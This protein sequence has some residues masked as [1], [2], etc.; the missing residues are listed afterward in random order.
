MKLV[1]R[2]SFPIEDIDVGD[3][4]RDL[5]EAWVAALAG[6]IKAE[7]QLQD[8]EL[9]RSGNRHR[10]SFGAHRLAAC[11]LLGLEHVPSKIMETETDHPELEIRL[12]EVMENIGRRELSA[13]DRAGHLAELKRIYEALNP[14]SKRGVAGAKKKHNPATAIFAVADE[15][16]G[17]IG[18]SE[19]SV[20]AAIALWDGL[21]PETRKALAGTWLADHQAQLSQLSRIEPKAQSKI[22]SLLLPP[23]EGVEPK[24]ATVSDAAAIVFN[25]VDPKKP[26]EALF[27]GLVKAWHKAPRKIQKRFVAYLHEHKAIGGRA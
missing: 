7:G 13:L 26:D 10:L 14:S 9:V 2:G 4:L 12:H 3:R 5:D 27:N 17:K 22:V 11:K 19:R 1:D 8:I 25:T 24:A 6:M 15:I 21:L 18:L 20:F 23:K 16:A